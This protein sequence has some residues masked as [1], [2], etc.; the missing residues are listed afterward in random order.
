M[1]HLTASTAIRIATDLVAERRITKRKALM[2]VEPDALTQVL[3]PVFDPEGAE[4]GPASAAGGL[5]GAG[6][7]TRAFD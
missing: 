5:S 3:A 4:V 1:I 2:R 7:S 6:S